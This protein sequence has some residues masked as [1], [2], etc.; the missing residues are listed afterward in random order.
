MR[1]VGDPGSVHEGE[2]DPG[3]V[4]EGE[5]GPGLCS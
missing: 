5:G 3:S 4:H 1:S 2:G